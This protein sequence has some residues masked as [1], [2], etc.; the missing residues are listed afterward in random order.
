MKVIYILLLDILCLLPACIRA[1]H[2]Q[3]NDA[4]WLTQKFDDFNSLNEVT[5]WTNGYDWGDINNGLECNKDSNV[6]CQSG[7]LTLKAEKLVNPITCNTNLYYYRS[8]AVHSK[9]SYKYGYW[10]I[11]AKMPIG[12]GFWPAFWVFGANASQCWWNEIDINEPSG[13]I[14]ESGLHTGFNYV[15]VDPS[16]SCDSGLSAGITKTYVGLISDPHK[17]AVLWEPNRL[18]WFY[19]NKQIKTIHDPVFTPNHSIKTLINFAIDP[20]FTPK[21]AT[22]F[23]AEFKADYLRISQLDLDCNTASTICTYN[24]LSSNKLRKNYTMGGSG[25]NTII[26]IGVE[27]PFWATDFILLQENT[28]VNRVTGGGAYALFYTTA[29][30][31]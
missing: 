20:W 6:T 25:C 4:T 24:G 26:D 9:F 19:D 21:P 23:P 27:N 28:T 11:N 2:F 18:T 29:C 12:Y 17:Y 16:I 13:E 1:Q 10:E 7:W 22:V 3:T 31:N 14:S 30:P 15:W 8:G 5:E